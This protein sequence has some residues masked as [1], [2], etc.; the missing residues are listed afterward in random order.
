MKKRIKTLIAVVLV[1]VLAMGI[2]AC[3][4]SSDGGSS[5]GGSSSGASGEVNEDISAIITE[6]SEN[7]SSAESMTYNMV[8]DMELAVMGMDFPTLTDV[9]VEMI[10]EPVQM[11]MEGAVDMGEMGSFDMQMYIVPEGDKLATYTGMGEDGD[12]QWMKSIVDMDAAEISQYNAA[13]SLNI[14]LKN[15]VNFE[16]VGKE[17][18]NGK[19]TVKYQGII[20]SDSMLEVLETSGMASQLETSGTAMDEETLK[21]LGDLP[22]TIWVDL[23]EKMVVK[24]SMDMT[25]N[26][27]NL[28]AKEAEKA[29]DDEEN[30]LGMVE[31]K[32][33]VVDATI[34]GVNNVESI[35]LPEGVEESAEAL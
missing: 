30:P 16:E 25:E 35:E 23:N 19:E 14:Y 8:M 9:D 10:V 29:S 17:T 22:V 2:S 27:T 34:T 15:A 6:I 1:I 31:F 20:T 3:N 28:M 33:M 18:I 26:L 7:M 4:K 13:Q 21:A 5:E 12:T 24:Y 32:K 11:K